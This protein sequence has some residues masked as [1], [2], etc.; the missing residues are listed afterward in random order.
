M[1]YGVTM[2]KQCYTHLSDTD[3]ETLSLGLTRGQSLRTMAKGL[4]RAPSTVSRELGRNT[5]A[6]PPLS[7][8]HGT[9]A[10]RSPRTSTAAAAQIPGS[11][12]VAVCEDA[13]GRGLLT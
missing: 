6:R 7:R 4:G 10:G 1:G 11:L 5:T 2:S 3:R 8:L 9:D 12:A 13:F